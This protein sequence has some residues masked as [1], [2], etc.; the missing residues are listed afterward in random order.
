VALFR[1]IRVIVA[2]SMAHGDLDLSNVLVEQHNTHVILRL[3]DYDNTWIPELVGRNQTEHGH[4]NF[5]H[6]SFMPPH[7]RPYYAGMDRFSALVIYISLKMLVSHP[8]L[9]DDWGANEADRLLLSE[10]DYQNA[11]LV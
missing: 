10:Q 3:I 2:V 6:P 4:E 1:M 7:Q 8:R 9:Y 5:Q 11:G